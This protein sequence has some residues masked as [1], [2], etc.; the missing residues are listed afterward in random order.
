MVSDRNCHFM[1]IVRFVFMHLLYY[2]IVSNSIIVKLLIRAFILFSAFSR[3]TS[4]EK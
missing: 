2:A 3:R 4:T 1:G